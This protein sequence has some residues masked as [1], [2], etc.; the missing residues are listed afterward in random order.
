MKK[1]IEFIL[2][3]H[4]DFAE[5]IEGCTQEE[6]NVL[7]E[8]IPTSNMPEEYKDFLRYMGKNP[9][10]VIGLRRNWKG[11]VENRTNPRMIVD[12]DYNSVLRYFKKAKK[13]NWQVG[14][15]PEDYGE[16]SKDFFM[17]GIDNLG[18][19][20][21]NLLLDLKDPHLS[22]VEYSPT[23][24]RFVHAPSFEDFLFDIPFHRTLKKY[25]Y[26]RK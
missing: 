8:L 1:L 19:D 21:G 5:E 25:Q 26:S 16:D 17:F 10:R 2:Q 13:K 14:C 15:W 11:E 22:V 24:N 6:I 12:I 7:E 23:L 18:N 4:P 3:S 9:G 20:N